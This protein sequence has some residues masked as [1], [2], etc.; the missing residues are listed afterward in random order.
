MDARKKLEIGSR[1]C[2]V[3]RENY[4]CSCGCMC[5]TYKMAGKKQN[6]D[7]MWKLLEA[8]EVYENAYNQYLSWIMCTWD[9]LKDHIAKKRRK[10]LW[11][12]TALHA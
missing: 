2:Y 8:D 12:N 7:P 4:D 11:T 3:P 1:S 5:M 10:I 6:I 9:A